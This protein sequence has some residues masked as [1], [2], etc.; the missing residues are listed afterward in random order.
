LLATWDILSPTSDYYGNFAVV[1]VE[2]IAT[3]FNYDGRINNVISP[4]VVNGIPITT[5][6]GSNN[7]VFAASDQRPNGPQ[8]D[9]LFTPDFDLTGKT[10]IWMAYHN[11]FS[12]E[13]GELGGIEY[14]I[15]Q[16]A[17]WLPVVYMIAAASA[18]VTNGVVDP[19]S[20]M[21]NSFS[22]VQPNNCGA[23]PSTQNY[24][25]FLGVDSSLWGTLIPYISLRVPGDHVTWHT[26]EKF[27]L[28]QADNQAHVRF[29]FVFTGK[30]YWDWGFDSF[31]LYSITPE[32]LQ[33]TSV[34]K[35][36]ASVT[37]NWNGTGA[38]SASGL[39][40]NSSLT[41]PGGWVNIPGTIGLST[42]TEAA[43]A[44]P[45]YYRAIRY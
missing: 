20:T 15:D 30:D 18:I 10:N 8:V 45:V 42:F 41:T 24:G 34:A 36:G 23:D 7:I 5:P 19:W 38:N 11:M 6:L 3:H 25:T 21:T 22:R 9:Y 33:I 17:T 40:K 2:I 27:R 26:V 1:P 29:R 35:S 39:Q 16:G 44:G 37:I 14:S 13:N 32:P 31:G 28:P 12:Q 4:L 43:S